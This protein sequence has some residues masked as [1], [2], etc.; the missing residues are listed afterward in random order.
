MGKENETGACSHTLTHSLC[1]INIQLYAHGLFT[2]KSGTGSQTTL[3]L[4]V[5]PFVWAAAAV[6]WWQKIWNPYQN[7]NRESFV[8][9]QCDTVSTQCQQQTV[10]FKLHKGCIQLLCCWGLCY[11]LYA[12]WLLG[13]VAQLAYHLSAAWWCC[14]LGEASW[15]CCVTRDNHRSCSCVKYS[16]QVFISREQTE[17]DFVVWTNKISLWYL[18]W[19]NES[20]H[21][22]NCFLLFQATVSLSVIVALCLCCA[23][24]SKK[25]VETS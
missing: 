10:T 1:L 8:L 4:P 16:L 2:Y 6:E 13:S 5:L 12:S 11:F 15:L 24:E 25:H 17:R 20:C 22:T 7:I 19:R 21:I 9:Q 3:V 23:G 18:S 14:R